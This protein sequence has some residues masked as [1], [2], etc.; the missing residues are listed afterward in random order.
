MLSFDIP[1][2]WGSSAPREDF[3]G[4]L[5]R[6]IDGLFR[7]F[8]RRR[9]ASTGAGVFP[10]VNVYAT[11]DGYVLT[12][13]VPGLQPE[14]FEVAV[15][16]NRVTIRGERRTQTPPS[17]EA[18]LHRQERQSGV[19]RRMLELPVAVDSAKAEAV[20]RQGVLMVRLPKAPE[21]QPRK[22][23]VHAS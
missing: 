15:E 21:F 19:F 13:E 18:G 14:D 8:G 3:Y 2:L 10:P 23:T 17:A 16:N 5:Q 20:Y 4:D 7:R 12:A 9:T 22:I 11:G 6:E 1:D